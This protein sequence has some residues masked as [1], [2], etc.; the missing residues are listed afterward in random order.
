[1]IC[2]RSRQRFLI[3]VRLRPALFDVQLSKCS[4]I[5]F[6]GAALIETRNPQT[7]RN[8]GRELRH[9]GHVVAPAAIGCDVLGTVETSRFTNEA[10][11]L[12]AIGQVQ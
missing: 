1:M 12:A 8:R 6:M 3:E 2:L 10:F 7:L 5:R 4:V 11:D 9:C